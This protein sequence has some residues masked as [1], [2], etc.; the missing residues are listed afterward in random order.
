MTQQIPFTIHLISDAEPGSGFGNQLVNGIL[1]R[2]HRGRPVVRASHVKGLM[3][4]RLRQIWWP[5]FSPRDA[6]QAD[7]VEQAVFGAEGAGGDDGAASRVQL[8]DLVVQGEATPLTVTR[9]ALGELGTVRGT[10]LRTDE[11]LPCGTPLAGTLLVEAEPGS[12][13]DLA[14]RLALCAVEAIGGGRNRGC[15]AC[16][17]ELLGEDRTPGK[18]LLALAARFAEEG[19]PRLHTFG[20]AAR[21]CQL[22]AEDVAVWA[23]LQ[24]SAESPV[25]CP[26]TPV[27][28]NNI[29]RSGLQIPASAVQGAI[30]HRLSRLD[31]AL[32]SACYADE[33]FRAWPLLPAAGHGHQGAVPQPTLCSLTHRMSKLANEAG[34]HDF[35]D[36]SIRPYDWR[37]VAAGSPL[38]ATGGALLRDAADHVSV[39][40]GADIPRS[41]SAHGVHRDGQGDRNLFTVEAVAPL[42]W[43]GLVALPAEAAAAL[44]Q[45]LADDPHVAFGKARS[46]RGS[47][48]LELQVVSPADLSA[49]PLADDMTGKVL[50]VQSPVAIPDDAPV[51]SCEELLAGLV[52]DAG[53]GE[54]KECHGAAGVR[55]G[56]NRHGLGSRGTQ[57]N[58]LRAVRCILPGSVVVLERPPEG[59]LQRLLEGVG[60]GR[61]AGFGGLLPHPGIAISLLQPAPE[62]VQLSSKDRAGKV[63]LDLWRQATARGAGPAPSQI[64]ALAE[65]LR[66]DPATALDHLTRQRK[67]S[68]RHYRPWKNVIDEVKALING[69]KDEVGREAAVKALRVWQDLSIIHRNRDKE[70]S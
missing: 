67:R 68:E 65:R 70:T 12:V 40:R 55:F 23:R 46:V 13:V 33:R 54:V 1:T 26:E 9:T 27:V 35:E 5:V 14:A 69:S 11:A 29:I 34:E 18:L 4:E 8:M 57:G 47:G 59:L 20:P 10:S 63:G 44:E 16:R 25:C 38:K 7:A 22:N 37:E 19:V 53:W 45:S 52:Q 48:R 21:A 56:W 17:V 24:F 28:G 36:A 3:R 6:A 61:R 64:S 66:Q 31:D 51:G 32:A 30:L 49:P 60:G 2:D 42:T 58:R 43:S 41:L 39:W 62:R 15:G 50:V